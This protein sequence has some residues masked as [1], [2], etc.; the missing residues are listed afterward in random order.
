MI[1]FVCEN[2]S[3]RIVKIFKQMK[4]A[5][6]YIDKNHHVL[7]INPKFYPSVVSLKINDILNEFDL[8]LNR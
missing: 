5:D 8:E 6:R 3:D 7:S 2:E 4:R 1:Y